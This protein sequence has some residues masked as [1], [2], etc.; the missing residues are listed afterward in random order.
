MRPV[1]GPGGE[2]SQA[3]VH[4][5]WRMALA[6]Q[7]AK[8]Y[9]G[10]AKLA[11]LAVAGSVGSGLADRFSDLELDC[12]WFSAPSDLDR[13]VPVDALGGELKHLWDYDQD[14]E[15]WSEDYRLGELDVTISNFLTGTIDRFLDEVVLRADTDPVKHMRLA[16]LQG[17][18]RPPRPLVIHRMS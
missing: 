4:A 16:A 9:A 3:N 11:A 6:G 1:A 8:A 15:E 14:E 18:R 10:N 17:S 2:V 12:Y 13:T 7:A 5:A